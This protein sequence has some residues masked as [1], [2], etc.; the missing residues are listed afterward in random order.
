MPMPTSFQQAQ[1]DWSNS[2]QCEHR[3]R[4]R[5]PWCSV[6]MDHWIGEGNDWS[7]GCIAF[8]NADLDGIYPTIMPR[9]TVLEVL[10]W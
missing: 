1:V 8:R 2:C 5:Y 3:W 6:G 4:D 7:L 9:V 10:T